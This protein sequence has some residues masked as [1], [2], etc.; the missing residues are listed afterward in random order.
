MK[1]LGAVL[2]LLAVGI[3]GSFVFETP[4]QAASG[5]P[6]VT[7]GNVP[8]P[9]AGTVAVSN[10]GSSTL[11]VSV[12]NPP[13]TQQ[14]SGTVDIGNSDADKYTHVGQKP[15]KLVN[16]RLGFPGSLRIN[17]STGNGEGFSIPDGFVFVLTDVQGSINCTAG[18]LLTVHIGAGNRDRNEIR[19]G[20]PGTGWATFERRYSTGLIFNSDSSA[21]GVGLYGQ[22]VGGG[23]SDLWA[24]GYFVPAD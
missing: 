8:L 14:V 11:P 1:T 18:E 6:V 16:L 9:V 17:P 10:L 12:T 4:T 22:L 7:I 24:Q 2:A 3:V 13:T 5:N 21:S 20:C 15:S 23:I 19:L